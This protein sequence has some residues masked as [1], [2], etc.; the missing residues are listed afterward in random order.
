MVF[1]LKLLHNQ[2]GILITPFIFIA[3]LTGVLYGITP[4][5]EALLYK[6]QLDAKPSAT[7]VS[8]PLSKQVNVA[9]HS[10]PRDTKIFSVRTPESPNQ[11]TRILY[12]TKAE[13]AL[14]TA[15]FVNP[16]TLQIQGQLHV[17]GTSGILPLRTFL[18][19]LHR[20][21]LLGEY[22]R[23]YSELAASWLGF[24]ALTGL[25]QW[26]IYRKKNV[27]SHTRHQKLR[28]H[29]YLG[30]VALPM[31]LFFS[32]TGLTWSKWTGENITQLRHLLKSDTPSLNL[33]LLHQTTS[34]PADPHAEHH[35]HMDLSKPMHTPML[36]LKKFDDII[37]IARDNGLMVSALQIKPSYNPDRAW[38]I[39]EMN[40]RWPIQIDALAID[41]TEHRIVD[42]IK[43][44]DFPWSA[45]L[46]R[47]GVDL[48]IGVLFGWI[49]QLILA[50]SATS[51]VLIIFFAYKAWWSYQR[52]MTTLQLFNQTVIQSWRTLNLLQKLLFILLLCSLYFLVPVWVIS[53]LVLHSLVF[54]A[55]FIGQKNNE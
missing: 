47:W 7:Q 50:I 6:T 51:I 52:P 32:I 19:H 20:S 17:Y 54:I 26:W 45:K 14:M 1:L 41:M 48:H 49:N 34:L 22:G 5:L 28:W 42:Q 24:F 44:E 43:F 31:L 37:S 2:L 16:Y 27:S 46:T 55:Q 4:Q 21:L 12:Q 35:M 15:I 13:P 18:N 9:V 10:L 29:Y 40:H 23:F 25:L 36:D 8:Q 33:N 53:I 30:L 3:A 39:E 11:A 38:S